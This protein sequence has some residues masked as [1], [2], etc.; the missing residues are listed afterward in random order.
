MPSVPGLHLKPPGPR[1]VPDRVGG[2]LICRQ[3]HIPGAV[4]RH[5]RLDRVRQHHRAQRGKPSRIEAVV[6][7][8]AGRRVSAWPGRVSQRNLSIHQRST[9]RPRPGRAVPGCHL[10][11]PLAAG[12]PTANRSQVTRPGQGQTAR[13]GPFGGGVNTAPGTPSGPQMRWSA[14]SGTSG[15][16]PFAAGTCG[17]AACGEADRDPNRCHLPCWPPPASAPGSRPP[18]AGPSPSVL[19]V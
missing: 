1:A 2:Q 5:A 10:D 15:T 19:A 7:E 9:A 18:P 8:P 13:T 3:R 12:Q 11:R 4:L 16:G 14:S 6:K 17:A